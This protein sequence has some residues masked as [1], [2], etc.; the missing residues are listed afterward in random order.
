[1]N[2]LIYPQYFYLL[3]IGSLILIQTIVSG[4]FLEQKTH[5]PPDEYKTYYLTQEDKEKVPYKGFDTLTFLNVNN[6]DTNVFISTAYSQGFVNTTYPLNIDCSG[7]HA[8]LEQIKYTFISS[9]YPNNLFF[10]I[11]INNNGHGHEIKTTFNYNVFTTATDFINPPYAYDSITIQNKV[12]YQ[13]K[14]IFNDDFPNS[15]IYYMLYNKTEGII[16]IKLKDGNNW[17]LISKK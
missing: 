12:Y 8:D 2:K 3:I 13:V 6:N 11:G 16:Q 4:C 9:T 15:P 17:E 5:C 10:Q 7:G 1:M 14:Y